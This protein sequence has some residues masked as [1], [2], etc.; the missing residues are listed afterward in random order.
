LKNWKIAGIVLLAI[1]I[2]SI[3]VLT[4]CN[5]T[6]W[7][8]PVAE[9]VLISLNNED[10]AGFSKDFDSSLAAELPAEAFP[11]ILNSTTG[12]WGKYIEGS[13]KMNSYNFENGV[14]RIEYTCKF[15]NNDNVY[16]GLAFQKIDNVQKIIGIKLE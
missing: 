6:K 11:Q 8:H 14:T 13:K 12:A 3:P 4:G 1:F 10:Y 7:A 9:N 15:E 2:S 16:Y 5:V